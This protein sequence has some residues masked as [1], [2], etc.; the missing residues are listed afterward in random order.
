[1]RRLVVGALILAGCQSPPSVDLAVNPTPR[2]VAATQAEP[3]Q[4]KKLDQPPA[5]RAKDLAPSEE[6]TELP[7]HAVEPPQELPSAFDPP[8]VEQPEEL[9]PT[10]VEDVPSP[11]PSAKL[12][13]PPYPTAPVPARPQPQLPMP[14]PQALPGH[15]SLPQAT[16]QLPAPKSPYPSATRISHAPPARPLPPTAGLPGAV[17][18]GYP[19]APPPPGAMPRRAPQLP[20][21][22]A[23]PTMR[24]HQPERELEQAYRQSRADAL[25]QKYH[26]GR[27][28]WNA[29]S[30]QVDLSATA[31]LPPTMPPSIPGQNGVPEAFRAS[32]VKRQQ[33]QSYRQSP[34]VPNPVPPNPS[35]SFQP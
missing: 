27:A 19:T 31:P 14:V 6:Q 28:V 12:P 7:S 16:H 32:E 3:P 23:P 25:N 29:H 5:D 18:P 30:P 1:M 10:Q 20:G 35:G 34:S 22:A 21:Q 9:P 26:G 8:A 13:E 17:P 33:W 15:P 11:P 24:A 2:H 4:E